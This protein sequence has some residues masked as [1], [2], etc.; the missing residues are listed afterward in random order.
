MAQ[1]GVKRS[2]MAVAHQRVKFHSNRIS[3]LLQLL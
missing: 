1:L 2:P 3:C